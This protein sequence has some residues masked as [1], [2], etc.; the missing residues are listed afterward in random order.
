MET[1]EMMCKHCGLFHA[2]FVLV[3]EKVVGRELSA[4]YWR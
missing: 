3:G 4:H 2:H 1:L